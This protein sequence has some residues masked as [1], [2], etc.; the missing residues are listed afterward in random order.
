M[1][2]YTT[3]CCAAL[4]LCS[5]I[6]AQSTSDHMT[7]RFNAPVMVGETSIPAGECDIQVMHG[8]SDNILLVLRSQAGP[9]VVT[10]ASRMSEEDTDGK[11][12]VVL[13]R[14]GNDMHLYR[15]MFADGTGFQLPE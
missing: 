11:S 12:S 8:A 10:V 2:I 4:A 3:L 1:K 15:I 5:A 6:Y 13:N 14:S 9:E 7:V